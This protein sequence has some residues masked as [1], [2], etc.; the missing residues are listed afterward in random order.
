MLPVV[1][2]CPALTQSL[3]TKCLSP[4]RPRPQNSINQVA[5]EMYVNNRNIFLTVLEAVGLRLG[6]RCDFSP[7]VQ[8]VGFLTY[9]HSKSL[10]WIPFIRAPSPNPNHEAPPCWPNYP[11]RAPPPNTITLRMRISTYEH[12][13]EINIQSIACRPPK[14]LT[15]TLHWPSCMLLAPSPPT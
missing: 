10:H 15:D 8:T 13:E 7:V 3:L 5:I 11:P 14:H 2:T 9:P 6:S 4:F 12:K 1:T